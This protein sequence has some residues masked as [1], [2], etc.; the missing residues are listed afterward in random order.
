MQSARSR[1][2]DP[3]NPQPSQCAYY[4]RPG[5][6]CTARVWKDGEPFCIYHDIA[7][8]IAQDPRSYTRQ[9]AREAL[10]AARSPRQSAAR[11]PGQ[12]VPPLT[13]DKSGLRSARAA[14]IGQPTGR[15]QARAQATACLTLVKPAKE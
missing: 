3:M 8:T 12:P 5:Q 9:P 2:I 1:L 6:R 4:I 10:R 11:R 13:G 7:V 15:E 14:G